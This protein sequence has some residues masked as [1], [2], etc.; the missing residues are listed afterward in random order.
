MKN[1][2]IAF[3]LLGLSTDQ[4]ATIADPTTV[5]GGLEISSAI[6]TDYIKRYVG[7]GILL[8]FMSGGD[9][10]L[11]I[12]ASTHFEIAEESWTLLSNSNNEDVV[13]P[14]DFLN[15]L[16]AIAVGATRGILHGKTDG[17]AFNKYILPLIDV[18]K[19]EVGDVIVPKE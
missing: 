18:S 12:E 11:Q 13:L 16:T 5:E 6:K 1:Q 4:F 17:T 8:K 10:F 9:V 14:K 19:L 7:I 15:H 2:P 3:T